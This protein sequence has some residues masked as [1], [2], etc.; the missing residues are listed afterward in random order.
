MKV[1]IMIS[2]LLGDSD[3]KEEEE[4]EEEEEDPEP[5]PI[6]PYRRKKPSSNVSVVERP[7]SAILQKI[8]GDIMRMLM[9]NQPVEPLRLTPKHTNM[10][11][12][13]TSSFGNLFAKMRRTLT[14]TSRRND[15]LVSSDSEWNAKRASYFDFD[16]R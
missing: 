13:R 15:A 6:Q 1:V 9:E 5:M 7:Q 8:E 16:Y 3:E 14:I 2:K 4:E 11:Q 10:A 12:K